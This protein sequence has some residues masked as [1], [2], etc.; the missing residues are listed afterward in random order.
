M[1]KG[2]E[3]SQTISS[4]AQTTTMS[5]TNRENNSNYIKENKDILLTRTKRKQMTESLRARTN[6]F[7]K[8]ST[9]LADLVKEGRYNVKEEPEYAQNFKQFSTPL[10]R[11]L[12]EEY[13]NSV[14]N[15][16]YYF[17]EEQ[18]QMT[19]E[20]A[21]SEAIELFERG[22]LDES[23]VIMTDVIAGLPTQETLSFCAQVMM[24]KH[25]YE[26]AIDILTRVIEM[27]PM[28]PA[29]Y[30]NRGECYVQLGMSDQARDE[31]D[32]YLKLEVPSDYQVL[33][34]LGKCR[35]TTNDHVG[36]LDSFDKAIAMAEEQG[37]PNAYAYYLRGDV[38]YQM[39]NI[40]RAS[41]DFKK[42]I[43]ID[44]DFPKPYEQTALERMY[45]IAISVYLCMLLYLSI[46]TSSRD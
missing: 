17:D 13:R 9:F 41:T 38:Y 20:S 37:Q 7:R 33:I 16:E 30:L 14:R 22:E 18:V 40:E 28:N 1:N 2:R 11:Q 26:E 29:P 35:A 42:V 25:M 31:I 12:V 43:E 21:F 39:D 4:T 3:P 46:S 5:Q 27:N 15:S 23:L 44:P 45:F 8:P 34:T 19:H 6:R 10:S 32:K 36:A 24:K